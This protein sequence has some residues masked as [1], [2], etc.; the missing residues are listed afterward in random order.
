MSNMSQRL[1][2]ALPPISELVMH[3]KPMLLI[4]RAMSADETSMI[5]EVDITA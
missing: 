5:A 4:D 1:N 3:A 2:H